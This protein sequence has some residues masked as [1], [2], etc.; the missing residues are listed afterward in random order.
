MSS[1]S[2]VRQHHNLN[3]LNTCARETMIFGARRNKYEV[4]AIKEHTVQIHDRRRGIRTIHLNNCR[5]H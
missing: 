3:M 2:G 5:L 4:E 1:K